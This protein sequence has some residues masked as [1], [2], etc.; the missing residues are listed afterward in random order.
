MEV[1]VG[2]TGRTRFAGRTAV[3]FGSDDTVHELAVGGRVAGGNGRPAVG[4]G[5]VGGHFGV[6]VR[7]SRER[8]GSDGE[9]EG[10]GV[11]ERD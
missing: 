3:D 8:R 6:L 11:R 1:D 4:G 7:S 2:A 5:E 10:R 9:N